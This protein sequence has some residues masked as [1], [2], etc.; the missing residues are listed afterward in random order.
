MAAELEASVVFW[1][2]FMI[3]LT[4]YESYTVPSDNDYE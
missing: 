2:V 3:H 4:N 1:I